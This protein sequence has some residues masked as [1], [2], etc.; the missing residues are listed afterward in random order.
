MSASGHGAA[1]NRPASDPPDAGSPGDVERLP[2][3]WAAVPVLSL[4]ILSWAPFLY[5]SVRTHARKFQIATAVYLSLAIVAGVLVAVSGHGHGAL[6]EVAGLLLIMLAGA[7]CVHTLSIRSEYGRQLALA[8]DPRL[9]V[10]EQRADLRERALRLV[11]EDPQ[12]AISLGVGRPDLP[13]SFDGGLVDVNHAGVEALAT[14][15]G[16]DSARAKRIVELRAGGGGFESLPDLDL[17]LDLN[18]DML[19][20]LKRHVVFLPRG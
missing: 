3:A 4:G 1:S 16:I 13:G 7:G 5:A 18:P 20:E 17:V 2:T 9:L 15:P 19:S 8:D 14:L 10:A 12:R 11:R 6:N